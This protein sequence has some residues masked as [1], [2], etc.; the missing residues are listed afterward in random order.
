MA[1]VFA[2]RG[3][4]IVTMTVVISLTKLTVHIAIAV[5]ISFS[6]RTRLV[7]VWKRFVIILK[8]ASMAVMKLHVQTAPNYSLHARKMVL[9]HV[10]LWTKSVTSFLTAMMQLMKRAVL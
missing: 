5:Q 7:S 8:I 10:L 2:S 9:L 1:Y 6:A 3:Y 4:V